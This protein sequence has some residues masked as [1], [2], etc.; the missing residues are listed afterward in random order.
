MATS[1]MTDSQLRL[2]FEAGV[3]AEGKVIYK[4]KNFNNIKTSAT[5]DQLFSVAQ[6]LV[7]LQQYTLSAIERNDS[8]LLGL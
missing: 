1:M 4:N 7:G 3:N 6:S 2:V 5:T 8:N